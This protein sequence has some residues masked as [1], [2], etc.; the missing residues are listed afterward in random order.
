MNWAWLLAK[1]REGRAV[2]VI[3]DVGCDTP[4]SAP[5]E[6]CQQVSVSYL[7]GPRP[8]VFQHVSRL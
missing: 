6:P 5:I 8:D 2:K 3:M 1:T 4:L 7:P